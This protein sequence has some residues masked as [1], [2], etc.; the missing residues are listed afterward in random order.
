MMRTPRT[1]FGPGFSLAIV[2]RP[3]ASSAIGRDAPDGLAG[4]RQEHVEDRQRAADLAG[5]QV[6]LHLLGDEEAEAQ[7]RAQRALDIVER[8]GDAA[9]RQPRQVRHR[10][11]PA[12]ARS[13]RRSSP[14]NRTRWRRGSPGPTEHVEHGRLAAPPDWLRPRRGSSRAGA[15]RAG[16]RRRRRIWHGAAR[17]DPGQRHQR[18][19]GRRLHAGEEFRGVVGR[20]RIGANGKHGRKQHGG[21][22]GRSLVSKCSMFIRD[23]RM[24]PRGLD[25]PACGTRRKSAGLKT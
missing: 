21:S 17:P 18:R 6:G 7:D 24:R 4:A 12:P 23:L 13:A 9:A 22:K 10:A 15:V 19:V 14:S 3:C 16:R 5:A 25:L 20:V 2:R 8:G 1:A 11:R